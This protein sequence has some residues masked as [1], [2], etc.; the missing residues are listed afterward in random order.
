M[1]HV[2]AKRSSRSIH[3]VVRAGQVGCGRWH[4]NALESRSCDVPVPAPRVDTGRVSH[5]RLSSWRRRAVA[6][7][8]R[9]SFSLF[10]P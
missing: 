8:R 6:V 1:G 5:L 3:R 7:S 4:G 9:R 10:S 2:W